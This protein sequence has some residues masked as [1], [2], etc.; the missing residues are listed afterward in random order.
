LAE[1]SAAT[2]SVCNEG[3]VC[4]SNPA[5]A[6]VSNTMMRARR[7]SEARPRHGASGGLR[8]SQMMM[9]AASA[10]TPAPKKRG[11]VSSKPTMECHPFEHDEAERGQYDPGPD[12]K[13]AAMSCVNVHGVVQRR[14]SEAIGRLELG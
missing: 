5:S 14:K 12:L 6:A 3:E 1:R 13:H 7:P 8:R 11:R 4:S 9:T 10:T 2:T